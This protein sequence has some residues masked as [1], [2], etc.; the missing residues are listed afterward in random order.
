[1]NNKDKKWTVNH[2]NNEEIS[3]VYKR[4]NSNT[5]G[6]SG[7]SK[8]ILFVNHKDETMVDE[9]CLI[10]PTKEEKEEFQKQKKI[11]LKSFN[12]R[13]KLYK[14]VAQFLADKLNDIEFDPDKM[15]IK[16]I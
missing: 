14:K 13:S 10:K 3:L 2:F 4:R 15:S 8:I 1:M 9:D 11:Y 16:E 5:F 6:W 12:E 7:K